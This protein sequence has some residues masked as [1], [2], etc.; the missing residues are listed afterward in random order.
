VSGLAAGD[1]EVEGREVFKI[2][3]SAFETTLPAHHLYVCEE[4]APPL[5]SH[6]LFRDFLRA[7]PAHVAA[8][9]LE[10]IEAA[11]RAD[12]DRKLYMD[13]KAPAYARIIAEAL[14]LLDD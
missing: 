10:K 1:Q 14:L 13:L 9:S 6:R 5:R 8:L 12:H 2:R 11:E 4:G 3:D 7:R